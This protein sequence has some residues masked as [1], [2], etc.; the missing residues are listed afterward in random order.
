MG[1]FSIVEA[2]RDAEAFAS[3]INAEAFQERLIHPA[4]GD[5]ARHYYPIVFDNALIDMSFIVMDKEL[6]VLLVQCSAKDGVVSHFGFPVRFF[7]DPALPAA[8]FRKG[9]S[10]AFRHLEDAAAATKGAEKAQISGGMQDGTLSVPDRVCLDRGG[11]PR[12]RMRAEADLSLDEDELRR[13]LR[14]SYKS[15]IN[16]G[17]RNIRMT[18]FNK[19]NPD[20]EMSEA[21]RAF[22]V[23]IAGKETHTDADWQCLFDHLKRGGGELSLGYFEEDE[24]LVSGTL[25]VDGE[26]T[27]SYFSA[28]YERER[29]DK[30]MGHWPLFDAMMRA[31]NRSLGYFDFGEFFAK[32]SV[33]D[34]E[35]HIG[36]FKKGFTSR[37]LCE[38]VW[39]VPLKKAP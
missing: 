35:Y 1:R 5:F 4:Y 12:L 16:W 22:H 34:K 20:P 24:A 11:V 32:G 30:P 33:E 18:Y 26:Q 7:V 27:T 39:E 28:A 37:H 36:F 29:F 25:V 6:P 15:L 14:D 23:K 21:Y 38:T 9:L 13:N 8:A 2:Q 17:Q 19:D 3:A 31:K 10:F